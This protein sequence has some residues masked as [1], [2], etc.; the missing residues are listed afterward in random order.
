MKLCSIWILYAIKGERMRNSDTGTPAPI[1]QC[2][3]DI[4]DCVFEKYKNLK[5]WFLILISNTV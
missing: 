5:V 3:K 4:H 1:V 2:L